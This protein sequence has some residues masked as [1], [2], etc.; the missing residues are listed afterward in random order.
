MPLLVLPPWGGRRRLAEH[1]PPEIGLDQPL[2]QFAGLIISAG[3]A[4]LWMPAFLLWTAAKAE[5]FE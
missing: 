4:I 2:L 5:V 1:L 3:R